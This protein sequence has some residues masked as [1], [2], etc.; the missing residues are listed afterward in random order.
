MTNNAAQNF[1]RVRVFDALH[2][3]GKDGES[4]FDIQA[5][6]I[7]CSLLTVSLGTS[8][9]V[10]EYVKEKRAARRDT[11]VVDDKPPAVELAAATPEAAQ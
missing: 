7:G 11:E 2:S 4:I 6:A 1:F 8:Y 5:G 3:S 9:F 10:W